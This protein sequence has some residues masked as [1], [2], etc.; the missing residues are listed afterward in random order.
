MTLVINAGRTLGRLVLV[1]ALAGCGSGAESSSD[2]GAGRGGTSGGGNGTEGDGA[3]GTNGAAGTTGQGGTSGAPGTGGGAGVGGG[4][5]TRG[6]AGN[7]GAAGQATGVGGMNCR[8]DVLLVQDRSGSMNNDQ[9]DA[10]CRG[11]CSANSKWSQMTAAVTNVVQS[12]QGSVNWGVKYFPDNDACDASM[13]PAVGIAPS[14]GAAL[15]DSLAR[16]LPGGTT[17]TRD[18]ITF[19]TT[20][21]QS[22]TD[23]NPKF[24]LLA[25]DGLP[26]C[27]IGCAAMATASSVCSMTDNPNEDLAV[28][29]AVMAA[30]AQGIKT[31]VVGIGNVATA[32]NTLNLLAIDGGRANRR[33][34]F[35][36]RRVRR[37]GAGGSPHQHRGQDRRL[38]GQPL[39]RL[40][41]PASVACT[42][43]ALW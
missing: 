39:S 6:A 9:N 20:Y 26:N 1:V 30:A 4:A 21:L 10:T 42:M 37:S 12:T 17:P 41:G 27:P 28:E 14:N 22:L 2:A 8:P 38:P 11:G 24:L 5:G 35:L 33:R 29:E 25:T 13:P 36:L 40:F 18:A 3:A 43:S 31:F 16:T 32:Q 23:T 34:Q 15:A 7:G 19:G